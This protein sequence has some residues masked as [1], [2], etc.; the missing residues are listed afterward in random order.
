VCTQTNS[1]IITPARE[2]QLL[3][4]WRFT[5][6]QFVLV[7]SPLR[8]TARFFFQLNTC[9]HSPYATSSL[10]RGWVCR[11]QLPLVL[12][13]AVILRP[14]S[15]G[16]NDHILLSQIRDSP[17]LEDQVPVFIS[18]RNRVAHLYPKELGSLSVAFTTR[19]ATVEIIRT[20]STPWR[21]GL[22]GLDA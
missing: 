19:R 17:N 15:R 13:S 9:A 7:P 14:E 5:A 12:A 11:L 22:L 3:Y 4:D 2:S 18:P 8:L 21:V 16:T 20:A 10:R 6:N 1:Y